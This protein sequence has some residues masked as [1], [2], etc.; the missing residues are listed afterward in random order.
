MLFWFGTTT[1][2]KNLGRGLFDCPKCLKQTPYAIKELQRYFTLY[3]ARIMP[4]EVVA[5]YA[6]CMICKARFK[7]SVADGN[8]DRDIIV[9]TTGDKIR[10]ALGGIGTI[11]TMI[12]I[13]YGLGCIIA[14]YYQR[15]SVVASTIN[16]DNPVQ[17]IVANASDTPQ[18]IRFL[19][20]TQVEE[21]ILDKKGVKL[22][23]NYKESKVTVCVGAKSIGATLDDHNTMN[24][25]SIDNQG[26]LRCISE[27]V[28]D[29]NKYE[30]TKTY[31][32]S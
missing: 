2:V 17:L 3:T 23:E 15:H 10:R 30:E 16:K 24:I 21:F 28:E 8:E 19:Q 32:F 14:D 25:V 26:R 11:C 1:K 29:F 9:E 31:L 5:R 27:S 20:G 6:L 22:W 4:L 13:A 12:W 7:P 18:T